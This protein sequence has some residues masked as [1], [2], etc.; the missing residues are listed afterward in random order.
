MARG[1]VSDTV[2]CEDTWHVANDIADMIDLFGLGGRIKASILMQE[3]YE[4]HPASKAFLQAVYGAGS[5]VDGLADDHPDILRVAGEGAGKE[6]FDVRTFREA[7]ARR[8]VDVP[9][10]R[11]PPPN[12][13]EPRVPPPIR[14]FKSR[15]KPIELRAR[16]TTLSESRS[17]ATLSSRFDADADV[18]EDAHAHAD[19]SST[20][21]R[22]FEAF[23]RAEKDIDAYFY[24]AAARAADASGSSR[25]RLATLLGERARVKY[26]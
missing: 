11:V 17:D 2:D 18:A 23:A 4:A 21:T 16:T 19:A 9:E 13:P 25:K 6:V 1:T 14:V 5:K 12:V 26:D 22:N 20:S 3:L 15:N 10:P 24:P 7:N 8:N